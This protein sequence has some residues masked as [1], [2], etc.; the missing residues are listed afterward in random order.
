[1]I[2][3]PPKQNKLQAAT[4]R[5]I[6]QLDRTRAY[7]DAA[8]PA[9]KAPEDDP[10]VQ[11]CFQTIVLMLHTFL[12]EHYRLLITT[13]TFWEADAVR[14]Y[15]VKKYPDEALTI[16]A[17]PAGQLARRAAREASSFGGDAKKLKAILTLL[18]TA[19]PF[20]DEWAETK[21]RDMVNVRNIITHQ[22]G[23]ADESNVPTVKSPDVIVK[24][25]IGSAGFYQLRISRQF[26]SDVLVATGQS[27]AKM[28]AALNEDPRYKIE[29]AVP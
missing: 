19:G 12:E 21:C 4:S 8:L 13:A 17:M 23:W 14:A 1:M 25:E 11:Y 28:E 24:K 10:N 20:A 18:F 27:V 16:E 26:L 22:G 7:L 6:H 2:P 29:A 5:F 9:L 15:L 3:P